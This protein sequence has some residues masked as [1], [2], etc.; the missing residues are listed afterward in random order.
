VADHVHVEDAG[1][2]EALDNMLWGNTDGGDEELGAA[3]DDD[4]NEFVKFT[5]GIVVAKRSR[6]RV[7]LEVAKPQ[8]ST[9]LVFLALPPTCG[10]K[11]STPK[12]AFLSLRKL[13]SSAICSRSISGV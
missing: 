6:V 10:I 12:G 3:V 4:A 7:L 13:L 11:R 5:F 2:V 9:N 8:D 1:F